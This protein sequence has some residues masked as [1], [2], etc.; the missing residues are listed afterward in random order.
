MKIRV[1]KPKLNFTCF[2]KPLKESDTKIPKKD[3]A[4]SK[5]KKDK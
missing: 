1:I 2:E 5:K 3:I 4:T